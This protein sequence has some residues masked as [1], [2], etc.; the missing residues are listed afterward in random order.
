MGETAGFASKI[1][2]KGFD[3]V[4]FAAQ[5]LA[6]YVV[7]AISLYN[8]TRGSTEK[9]LWISLLSSSVGYLLP[10]PISLKHVSHSP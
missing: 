7:I 2:A 8:L 9:D 5:V 1:K 10:S 6:V 3:L 4:F